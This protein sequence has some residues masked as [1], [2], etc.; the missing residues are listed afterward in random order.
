M[1]DNS[2][3]QHRPQSTLDQAIHGL[4]RSAVPDHAYVM[5]YV[6][7]GSHEVD[8]AS[9]LEPKNAQKLLEEAVEQLGL[10][11]NSANN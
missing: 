10:L 9:N 2:H 11:N 7:S 6:R 5:L 4:M 1:A 8:I 3:P